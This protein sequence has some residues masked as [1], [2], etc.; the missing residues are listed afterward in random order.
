LQGVPQQVEGRDFV[1]DEFYEEESRGS[2]DH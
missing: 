1:G 2:A